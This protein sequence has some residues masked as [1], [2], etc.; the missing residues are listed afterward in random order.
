M[1]KFSDAARTLAWC[2]QPPPVVPVSESLQRPSDDHATSC[3]TATDPAQRCSDLALSCIAKLTLRAATAQ[4]F[5]AHLEP[6]WT[7][8]GLLERV[9]EAVEIVGRRAGRI[10]DEDDKGIALVGSSVQILAAW[11]VS[12]GGSMSGFKAVEDWRGNGTGFRVLVQLFNALADIDSANMPGWEKVI[13][14][15]ALACA[16]C[17]RKGNKNNLQAH[18][19]PPPPLC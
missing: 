8:V 12:C 16:E 1:L 14:N 3:S 13:G 5:F 7:R 18:T 10:K 15:A 6:Y 9:S 4:S 19:N 11:L 2:L 17:C